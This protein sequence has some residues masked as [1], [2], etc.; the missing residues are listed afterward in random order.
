M[1]SCRSASYSRTSQFDHHSVPQFPHHHREQQP[2]SIFH[3]G[4]ANSIFSVQD[5]VLNQCRRHAASMTAGPIR[6]S[7]FAED[8]GG[9]QTRAASWAPDSPKKFAATR[10]AGRDAGGILKRLESLKYFNVALLR[11]N[12]KEIYSWLLLAFTVLIGY[13]FL[14][15]G[16]FSA[17]L[18]LSSAFQCFSLALLNMK[19]LN[20]RSVA[21][22][23]QRSLFLVTLS[24]ACRLGS[25]L[26]YNGY[27]PVDRSGDWVYQVA[28]VLSVALGV[29]LLVYS[30]RY[31]KSSL[32]QQRDKDTFWV[33]APIVAAL[34]LALII[35][36]RLNQ[37]FLADVA[38][39]FALYLETF[40][41]LPQLFM[42]GRLGGE[43]EALTSH[44]VA[45]MAAARFCAFMFWLYSFNELAPRASSFNLSGWA[46]LISYG[47]QSLF[48]VDFLY[49]YVKSIRIGRKMVINFF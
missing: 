7:A 2:T 23:S 11:N 22:V 15:D 41:M 48:F 35:H 30:M 18:T 29:H 42:M 8:L 16:T 4:V 38:W 6:G 10:L 13:K 26:F 20:Q 39:T 34:V 9:R 46:V 36:P 31:C 28:D 21:G 45:S 12:K 37:N 33:L 49:Y 47:I 32:Q 44:Y 17:I 27:L 19:V 1:A 43:I 3:S 25:T 40:A 5:S 14:S 24:L